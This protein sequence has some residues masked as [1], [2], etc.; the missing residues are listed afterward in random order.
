MEAE[1]ARR[2]WEEAHEERQRYFA[3]IDGMIRK[4]KRERQ[5]RWEAGVELEWEVRRRRYMA[6][7]GYRRVGVDE[8]E[9]MGLLTP[10]CSP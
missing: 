7:K 3:W 1:K 9:R 5:E 8:W 2:A 4:D 6:T 10:P